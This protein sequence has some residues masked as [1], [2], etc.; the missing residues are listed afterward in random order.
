[1]MKQTI[2]HSLHNWQYAR[3]LVWIESSG[4][5]AQQYITNWQLFL[6]SLFVSF[7]LQIHSFIR[8]E[9]IRNGFVFCLRWERNVELHFLIQQRAI[10]TAF[11]LQCFKFKFKCKIK[12]KNKSRHQSFARLT[13]S[14]SRR[15]TYARLS[16]LWLEICYF[17][18]PNYL[19]TCDRNELAPQIELQVERISFDRDFLS[20]TKRREKKTSCAT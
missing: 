20:V 16:R 13:H 12:Y 9:S 18:K 4:L 7:A 3:L 6:D 17:R 19:P 2:A 15:L 14:N 10:G 1:M 8:N 11:V 5:C